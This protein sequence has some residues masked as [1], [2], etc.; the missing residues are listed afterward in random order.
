ME[1]KC[2]MWTFSTQQQ[3]EIVVEREHQNVNRTKHDTPTQTGD[4]ALAKD[5]ATFFRTQL[6]LVPK[7]KNVINSNQHTAGREHAVRADLRDLSRSSAHSISIA[8]RAKSIE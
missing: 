1:R 4:L 5:P 3:I 2:G 8:Q 6:C 7:P